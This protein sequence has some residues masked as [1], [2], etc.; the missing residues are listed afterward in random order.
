MTMISDLEGSD[1]VESAEVIV[2]NMK[3]SFSTFNQNFE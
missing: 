3:E 1:N 2:G